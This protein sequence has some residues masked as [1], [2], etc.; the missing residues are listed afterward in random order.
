MH[1]PNCIIIADPILAGTYKANCSR[2]D[3]KCNCNCN[4]FDFS[5]RTFLVTSNTFK[6]QLLSFSS[7]PHYHLTPILTSF[8]LGPGL[9]RCCH[10]FRGS[11]PF[12]PCHSHLLWTASCNIELQQADLVPSCIDAPS[13]NSPLELRELRDPFILPRRLS[14]SP[15]HKGHVSPVAENRWLSFSAPQYRAEAMP[16]LLRILIKELYVISCSCARLS[17]CIAS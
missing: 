2:C 8:V 7:L 1:L 16:L 9:P 11:R 4:C 10:F 12:S 3:S 5:F 17:Q 13:P 6:P 15:Q 14:S